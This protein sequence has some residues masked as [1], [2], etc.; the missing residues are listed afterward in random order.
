MNVKRLVSLCLVAVMVA[1]AAPLLAES[2][3]AAGHGPGSAYARNLAFVG[4]RAVQLAKAIPQD[5]YGWRPM[6]GVRS[7]SESIMHMAA[8]NYFFAGRLGTETP[9]G[10]DMSNMEKITDQAKC[11]LMLEKSVAHLE[12]AFEAVED[13]SAKVDIFGREGTVEDMMQIAIGHVHEHF[14]Q[15]IAYAR[16][17]QVAPPWSQGSEG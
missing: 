7:V 6:E 8:A 16:S 1:G 12:K 2:H 10:V 11:V 4:D 5:A 3:E 15:L 13:P 9:E 17:N 14:G